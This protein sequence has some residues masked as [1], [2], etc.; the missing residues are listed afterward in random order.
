M[1]PCAEHY[2]PYRVEPSLPGTI[3]KKT[4]ETTMR[5]LDTRPQNM[6]LLAGMV[7]AWRVAY[8]SIT[9]L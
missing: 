5:Q 7:P 6:S 9:M 4:V 2:H 3:R 1:N 8:G